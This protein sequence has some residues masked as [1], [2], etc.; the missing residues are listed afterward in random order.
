MDFGV[1][2]TFFA[3][4][5]SFA[6]EAAGLAADARGVYTAVAA[7]LGLLVLLADGV[8]D[9]AALGFRGVRGVRAGS[10]PEFASTATA[11]SQVGATATPPAEPTTNFTL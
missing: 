2:D 1:D 10:S 7:G 5:A 9:E 3:A 6:A 11:D 8:A 4:V